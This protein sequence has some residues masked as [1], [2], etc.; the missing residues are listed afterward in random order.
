MS[1]GMSAGAS[2]FPEDGATYEALLADADHRMYR[3]KAARRGELQVAAPV[4][5]EP[6]FTTDVYT[7]AATSM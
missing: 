1:C 3:N 4:A 2:V 6:E 5:L 7:E